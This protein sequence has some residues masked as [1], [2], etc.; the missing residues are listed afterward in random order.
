MEGAFLSLEAANRR[1]DV[2][3]AAMAQAEES[4]RITANRYDAGLANVTELLHS[5]TS[6]SEAKTR[7]LAAVFDQRVATIMVEHAAGT[8]N[9]SSE[10]LRP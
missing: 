8:L 5:Q 9:P 2:G 7:Y 1:M 4:H 10:A 6:W 3:E